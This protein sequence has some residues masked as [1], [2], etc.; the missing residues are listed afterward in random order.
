MLFLIIGLSQFILSYLLKSDLDAKL[1]T[2]LK[3]G[4]RPRAIKRHAKIEAKT[5]LHLGCGAGFNDFTFKRY[6]KITG[7]DISKE[8]LEIAEK[9]NP[10]V[11]YLHGDMRT[12]R[13]S[14]CFD[15]VAIPDS[16]GYMIT[17]K[18]LRRAITTAYEHLKKGGVL[19]IVA[20]T[21]EQF[22]EN[23][24]IYTGS[25]E[26]TKIT[27]FEN[28]YVHDPAGSTYEATLINLIL[29]IGK[30]EIY[31]NRHILGLFKLKE[32]LSLLAEIGFKVKQEEVKHLYDRFIPGDGEYPLLMFVCIKI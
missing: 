11:A 24:F 1:R 14:K 21:V 5:L 28:D 12:V 27:V 23:N 20:N 18:D 3:T 9:L 29:R 30:L 31:S 19:L 4:V 8:M 16:I 7:V 32:W 26:D 13:L 17:L 15:A 6:F 2:V 10:G 22:K 25:K